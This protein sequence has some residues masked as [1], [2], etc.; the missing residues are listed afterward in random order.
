MSHVPADADAKKLCVELAKWESRSKKEPSGYVDDD[1]FGRVTE[2][3]RDF[4]SKAEKLY[5]NLAADLAA[6]LAA[7][8]KERDENKVELSVQYAKTE[9]PYKPEFANLFRSYERCFRALYDE[10][11]GKRAPAHFHRRGRPGRRPSCRPEVKAYALA[12]R[13]KNPKLTAKEIK[14]LCR[15]KFGE[16][17]PLP[18]TANAFRNWLNRKPAPQKDTK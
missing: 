15:E 11:N 6:D 13:D 14:G 3:L 2:T 10:I 9:E 4:R 1:L 8:L 17:E 12:E 18:P 7:N 5:A 16:G